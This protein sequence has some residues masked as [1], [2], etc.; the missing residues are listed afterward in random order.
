[1]VTDVFLFLFF[2]LYFPPTLITLPPVPFHL[3]NYHPW[4]SA[5]TP[6]GTCLVYTLHPHNHRYRCCQSHQ[7]QKV[8]ESAFLLG[9]HIP[10]RGILKSNQ[11]SL[12][13]TETRWSPYS[14]VKPQYLMFPLIE[15][16]LCFQRQCLWHSLLEGH[17]TSISLGERRTPGRECT[18]KL[19]W[20]PSRWSQPAT[21]RCADRSSRYL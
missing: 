14:A 7:W 2:I 12:I 17:M 1:M 6:Q 4:W 16:V 9:F 15:T 20:P 10:G 18:G 5:C 21:I 11:S 13:A 8:V 19:T 3:V